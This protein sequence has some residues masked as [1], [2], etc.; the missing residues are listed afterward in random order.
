ML[1]GRAGSGEADCGVAGG[2]E[3]DCGGRGLRGSRNRLAFDPFHLDPIRLGGLKVVEQPGP[4]DLS[5]FEE[6]VQPGDILTSE[7][8]AT[9]GFLDSRK[10]PMKA[11]DALE[12]LKVRV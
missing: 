10:A 1:W 2:G 9:P 8:G 4:G 6:L 7:G 5:F 12:E 3:A 11:F